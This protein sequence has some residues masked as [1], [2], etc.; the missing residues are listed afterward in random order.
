MTLLNPLLRARPLQLR[1]WVTTLETRSGRG[2]R[3]LLWGCLL[4]DYLIEG[5]EMVMR[6]GC[7]P[8]DDYDEAPM[9]NGLLLFGQRDF[10]HVLITVIA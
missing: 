9:S 6:E 3:W 2:G 10:G 1:K 5:E 4:V 7:R 8:N